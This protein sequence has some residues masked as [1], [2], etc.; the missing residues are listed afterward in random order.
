MSRERETKP[1]TRHH[2]RVS[3]VE[4][5]AEPAVGICEQIGTCSD[6]RCDIVGPVDDLRQRLLI[7]Q[8]KQDGVG[9][10][11]PANA[12]AGAVQPCDQSGF[13]HHFRSAGLPETVFEFQHT[14][15]PLIGWQMLDRP[16]D[17]LDRDASFGQIPDRKPIGGA[18]Y[19]KSASGSLAHRL[20]HPVVEH[21]PAVEEARGDEEGRPHPVPLQ[22]RQRHGVVVAIPIVEGDDR[23]SRRQGAVV[24]P[25]AGLE[26]VEH[27]ELHADPAEDP[28]EHAGV[29]LV[30]QQRVGLGER[31]VEVEHRQP[32][33]RSRRGGHRR[34]RAQDHGASTR[35]SASGEARSHSSRIISTQTMVPK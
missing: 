3:I 16:Q 17:P 1:C 34:Q 15:V 9:A 8:R 10:R 33:A 20:D 4:V 6:D 11:M 31:A 7:V 2:P 32:A 24:K 12:H 22:D 28:V 26:R 35:M 21:H 19:R 29:R 14:R 18:R 30:R 25:L 27:A 13:H 23:R 5:A